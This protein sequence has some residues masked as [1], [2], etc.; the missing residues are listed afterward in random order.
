LGNAQEVCERERAHL[1]RASGG[2]TSNTGRLDQDALE[3]PSI[4]ERQVTTELEGAIESG[5]IA[6]EDPELYACL[7][8]GTLQRYVARG[9][10]EGKTA[11]DLRHRAEPLSPMLAPAMGESS[12]S[13]S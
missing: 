6:L 12:G 4:L 11:G 3:L 8:L 9:C 7:L 13:D 2:F 5:E 10:R 1:S